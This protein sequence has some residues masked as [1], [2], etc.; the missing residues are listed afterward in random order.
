M[1]ERLSAVETVPELG[2]VLRFLRRRLARRRG[3]PELTSRD[4]AAETGWS[5]ASIAE[6]LA[7]K[8]LPPTE[9]FD[10]L[11][12][13]LGA[14]PSEQG[15]L[16][17]ARDRVEEWRRAD[18]S[19]PTRDVGAARSASS[20]DAR[21]ERVPDR[22]PG[23]RLSGSPTVG[24]DH[25]L[26]V[27]SHAVTEAGRGRGGAVFVLG[28][29]GIGK[30]RL[31][32]ETEK[33]A[34]ESRLA[35]LRGRASGSS[36]Q[37]RPL[38]EALFSVLRRTG[39]PDDPSLAPYRS[40]LSRL[41]PEWT[42]PRLPGADDS[43]VILAEGVLRVCGSLARDAGCVMV[44]D[45]L[46]DADR[47]TVTVVN[48]LVDN[49][50]SEG[51]LLVCAV[52]S[53]PGPV[54]D[55][56]RAAVRRGMAAVLE[57]SHLDGGAV[58]VLV[59]GCLGTPAEAIPEDVL[60][61]LIRTAGG[62]PFYV[63]EL[64]AGMLGSGR[65]ILS[66]D[67]WSST[68]MTRGG[69]P[70]AV[71][72]SVT[73]RVNRLG[74]LGLRV[75]RPAALLDRPFTGRL[76]GDIASVTRAELLEV[77][78]GAVDTHLVVVDAEAG[79][80][81]FR[82]ALIAE[83]LRAGMLPEERAELCRRVAPAIEA[84]Y[85]GLDDQWCVL[86]AELWHQAGENRRAAELFGQAGRRAAAQ[87]AVATA[88]TLLERGLALLGA[89]EPGQ[90]I[91]SAELLEALLDVL[92]VAGQITR[93]AEL[94]AR[95]DIEADPQRQASVHLRLARAAATAGQWRT[96]QRELERVRALTGPEPDPLMAARVDVVAAQLAFID[97][98]PGRLAQ[99][100]ALAERA[101]HAATLAPLPE[102]ACESLEVLGTCARIRDL[103]ESDALFNR[104]LDLAVRHDLTLWRI[105]LLFHLGA[106]DA[107]RSAD[108]ARLVEARST[109]LR[110]GAVVTALDIAAELA[111]VHLTRGEYDEAERYAQGCQETAHRLRLGELPVIA[112]GLRICVEAH[113]GRRTEVTALLAE[114]E[115]LGG[116]AS[117]F[118]SAVWGFGLTFCSLLEEDRDQA[119]AELTRAAAAESNR[120]PQYL[121]FTHGPRLFLAVLAGHEGRA[122]YQELLR[123][124]P[125]RARWNRQFLA[126]TEAVLA[127]RDGDRHEAA[128]A[129][130]DFQEIAKPYPLAYHI[131]LRLL[132]EAAI[133]DG[134]ARPG[135]W[136]R[137]AE[138]YF[139]TTGAARVAAVCRALLRRAGEPIMQRRH[140]SE[141]IPVELRQ[142][143]VT[144]REYEVLTLLAD[145]L[146]NREIGERLF[147]SPRTVETHVANLLAKTGQRDR[148][149]LARSV[150]HKSP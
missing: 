66:G 27:L 101:L 114:F 69:V 45:D 46:H 138:A 4:L 21:L 8:T 82:H 36:A 73:S 80:Y 50:A 122:E 84:A 9:R 108:P 142:I 31:L 115:R 116:G 93:A 87:G 135:P 20:A 72:D 141:A 3:E 89:E 71:L 105:R 14:A 44:L 55:L 52:R 37:F 49:V 33:I 26:S 54:V 47:D 7:G 147:L 145:R 129:V 106:Q 99:A 76:L 5:R 95:L 29:A 16:A 136:L 61:Q 146:S 10:E 96:G 102:I 30:T 92:V 68:G 144:V 58:R 56:A 111:V 62:N 41:V 125:G 91:G 60:E 13:L 131:G 149:A 34:T 53:E 148:T 59:A 81:A 140:G 118:A 113:R 25:E 85:P 90:H 124:A 18:A 42:V 74:P 67:R 65:L 109:A 98:V 70:D 40:A 38:S 100:E 104:A 43:L 64:L 83:A 75:L 78:R 77:L 121:S 24:R 119:L 117:D 11:V 130:Q 15:E 48:Y 22:R 19:A 35:V 88:I 107:I 103:D 137:A 2:E 112:L 79:E 139:T 120:P 17:T 110:A 28:E 32:R 12:R 63:E 128:R 127:G 51:V 94:G 143:G 57:P 86:A 97:P 6:Y 1:L 134:W 123:S 150:S 126:L 132:G 23:V 39:V 133:V